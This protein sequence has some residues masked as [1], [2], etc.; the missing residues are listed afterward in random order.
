MAKSFRQLTKWLVPSW[1][2]QDDGEKVLYSW[3]LLFDA[4]R[5]M[6][7]QSLLA[8]FPSY[9][10]ESANA[11]TGA[12][13]GIVRGRDETNAHYAAR[14]LRWRWPQG[15]RVRGNAFSLLEQFS[16][17]F[18]GVD[19][20]VIDV[21]GNRRERTADGTI[22]YSYGNAWDWDGQ[23][24]LPR[25]GRFWAVL[26]LSA[27]ASEQL[28][29]G[30]PDLWGGELGTPG[31]SIGQQGVT[32]EDV[33]ALRR[34]MRGRAWKPAGVRAE[35]VIV[36]L[37]GSDPTP[38]SA[39]LHW[40]HLRNDGVQEQTRS[41]DHRFWSLSP[42]VNNVYGGFPELFCEQFPLVDGS[43]YSGD[44]TNFPVSITLPTGEEYIG[45]PTSFPT[46]FQLVDDGDL[47]Q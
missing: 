26:D 13:R 41:V 27:I 9:T 4:W 38:N 25:W 45:D 33:N 32:A 21:K 6:L 43:L 2:N 15:H 23:G 29:F 3:M 5:E 40:S 10:G 18:G 19:G 44:P 31:Y 8:R 47:P 11:L 42:E 17:Y 39:W 35:W 22:S 30:D 7:R 37:D 1:L 28:D 36:S 34:M 46:S 20:Y 24:A 16:E 14:L 12:D